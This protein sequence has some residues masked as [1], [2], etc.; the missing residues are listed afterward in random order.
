MSMKKVQIGGKPT[1]KTAPT[2]DAWVESRSPVAEADH[3]R[4]TRGIA[5]EDQNRLRAARHEDR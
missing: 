3:Y 2:A 5:P 1:A 4:R